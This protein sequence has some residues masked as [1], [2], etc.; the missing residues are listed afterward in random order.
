MNADA[1]TDQ[2]IAEYQARIGRAAGAVEMP[3]M[4]TAQG[5][6]IT[7]GMLEALATEAEA[8]YDPATLRPWRPGPPSFGSGNPARA[9]TPPRVPPDDTRS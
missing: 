4:R 2:Q 9:H 6:P 3:D 1:L 7:E 8:G 5:E